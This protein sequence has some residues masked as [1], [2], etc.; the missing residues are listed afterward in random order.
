[1]QLDMANFP[2][3]WMREHEDA[4]TEDFE[5]TRD[6]LV[7]LL[8]REEKFVLVAGRMPSLSD[9]TEAS[10]EE[11][12]MRAQLFKTHRGS[13]VR[14]CAGM[15]IVGQASRLPAAISNAIEAFTKA[16]DAAKL[17]ALV[18]PTWAQLPAVNGDRNTQIG[19]DPKPGRDA[20]P[21]R[22]GSSLTFVGSMLQWPAMSVPSGY[23]GEGL[24]VG[25]QILARA[26]DES[27]IV[28]YGFAYEQ[29]SHYRRPPPSVP[30]LVPGQ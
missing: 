23:L 15:I 30:P 16:M 29:A 10:P 6:L 22:L 13:L 11:K 14:L 27:K 21:T 28:Q 4:E 24:P 7:D 19:D 3:I 8:A 1:M 17:D 18:F 9:L 2:I 12:K 5:A 20:A 26:W 25:L